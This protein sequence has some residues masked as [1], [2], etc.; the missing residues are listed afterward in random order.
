MLFI[1]YLLLRSK[2]ILCCLLS[3]NGSGPFKYL[4]SDSRPD[5]KLCQW[6]ALETRFKRKEFSFLVCSLGRLLQCSW[7]LQHQ[8]PAGPR[9]QLHPLAYPYRQLYDVIFLLRHFTMNSLPQYPKGEISSKFC[10]CGTATISVFL[11]YL[12]C[13]SG[14]IQHGLDFSPPVG[15]LFPGHL[16]SPWDS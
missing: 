8:C 15:S 13:I 11:L 9:S 2:F 3:K 4:S 6:R 12:F 16:L 14:C 7:C 5:V 10:Q 1:N